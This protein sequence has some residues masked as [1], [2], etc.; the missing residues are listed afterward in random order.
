MS[1][2]CDS[3]R[4]E[5]LHPFLNPQHDPRKLATQLSMA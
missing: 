4:D 3:R 1:G 5:D 2:T